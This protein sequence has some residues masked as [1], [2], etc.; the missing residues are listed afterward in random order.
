MSC[1]GA[2][3]K[4]KQKVMAKLARLYK[5]RAKLAIQEAALVNKLYVLKG[6]CR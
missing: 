5:K 1:F 2:T 6:R 3:E 4:R